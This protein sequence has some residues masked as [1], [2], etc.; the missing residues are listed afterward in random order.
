MV[1][2][3]GLSAENFN[4]KFFELPNGLRVIFSA[5]ENTRAVAIC[6]YFLTGVRDDPQDIQGA[7]FLY[8]YLLFQGTENFEPFD[9]VLFVN[10]NGGRIGGRVNYDNSFFY[11]VLPASQPQLDAALRYESERLKSLKLPD[12]VLDEQK[13]QVFNRLSHLLETNASQRA[14]TWVNGRLLEGT[15][16]EH[17]LYGDL[18]KIRTFSNDRI[19]ELYRNFQRLS[20]VVLL[21]AGRFDTSDL[22]NAVARYFPEIG[23]PSRSKVNFAA[24]GQDRNIYQY[25]NWLVPGLARP[26]VVYGFQGP[27]RLSADYLLVDFLYHYLLGEKISRL[28]YIL[29]KLNRRLN[30]DVDI[31]G[32]YSDYFEANALTIQ[33]SCGSR[34]NLE[35]AKEIFRQQLLVLQTYPLDNADM[36]QV[37]TQMEVEFLK[38]MSSLEGRCQQVAEFFHLFN[39]L[40]YANTYLA[41]LH[42]ISANDIIHTAQKYLGRDNQVILNVTA[43]K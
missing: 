34:A 10:R 29:N 9:Q 25:K 33:L 11:Q 22:R 2:A 1:L 8:Q 42:K 43:A 20:N 37:K 38:T 26:F 35:A 7:S 30:L 41:R 4:L 23:V 17:P 6:L 13:N 32:S 40:D 39:D 28:D 24:S 19:R 27:G 18:N 16:Y 14:W 36:R 12:A 21:V 3:L 5:D 15:A 31:S